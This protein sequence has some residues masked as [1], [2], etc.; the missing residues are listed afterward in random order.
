MEGTELPEGVIVQQWDN[1]AAPGLA[2][3]SGLD[4]VVSPTSHSYLDYPYSAIW[5]RKVYE[6]E[7]I[8]NDLPAELHRRILG[9]Q[10]NVW[11]E[12]LETASDVDYMTWP[13]A[14]AMAEVGWSLP[15]RR[16]WD[17]FRRRLEAWIGRRP[18]AERAS[19]AERADLYGDAS[20]LVPR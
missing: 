20:T 2:A 7:P 4:V 15:E 8:P 6:F 18:G 13:R 12:H 1:P 14:V 16:S 3:G 10:A 11:T 5:T 17:G 19:L 9:A